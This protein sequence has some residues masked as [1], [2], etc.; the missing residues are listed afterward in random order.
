MEKKKNLYEPVLNFRQNKPQMQIETVEH[1][2]LYEQAFFSTE[3]K[4]ESE[5]AQNTSAWD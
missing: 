5:Y 4:S 3:E 2:K 1:E